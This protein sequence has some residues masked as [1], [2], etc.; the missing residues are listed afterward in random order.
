MTQFFSPHCKCKQVAGFTLIESLIFLFIFAVVTLTFFQTFAYGT[1]L[2]QQSKYRLGAVSLANQK[3]EIVRSLDY[4]NI[5]TT[6]G[7]PAGDILEDQTVQVN[8]SLYYVHT[9]IQYVDNSYDGVLG[10]SP[11]DTTPNDYKRV[12]I[13]VSWG[14]KTDSEKIALFSTFAPS[15]VEQSVGGGILSINIL[16]SQGNGVQGATVHIVNSTVAPAVNVTTTTDASG[17]L[18][19]VGAPASSQKY[20]IT[21]SKSGY[22]GSATYAPYPTTA[23]NPVDVHASVV[24][25]T[26]NQASFVMDQSSTLELKTVDA[27]N[28]DLSDINFSLT[29]GRQ[30]GTNPTTLA[31]VY[32]LSETNS[33]DGSGEKQYTNRSYGNYT[34]TL[35][36]SETGYEFIQL[37]PEVTS[38]ANVISLA[39]NTSQSVKMILADKTVNSVL[40]T[41]VSGVD[42]SPISGASVHL[43]NDSLGYDATVTTS[44]FGKAFFPTTETPGL[45]AGNYDLDVSATGFTAKNDHAVVTSG[46]TTVTS[47]LNP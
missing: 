30:L 44:Q 14:N 26:V 13:E 33:T 2:I 45:L 15:G 41:V 46:L 18:F 1:T 23:F 6:T 3:M 35:D 29:G 19:L 25:S 4:D 12:R 20:Q 34:W 5:G 16:D 32:D 43:K 28:N 24:N 38:G 7:V 47:T 27:F 22:F 9:F 37:S 42:G 40:V 21:F 39:P 31:A 10:G 11:N 17:N 36:T 8:N